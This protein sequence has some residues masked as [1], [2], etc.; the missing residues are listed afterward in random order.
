[1]FCS[2]EKKA[3]ISVPLMDKCVKCR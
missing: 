3:A 2:C 1:M